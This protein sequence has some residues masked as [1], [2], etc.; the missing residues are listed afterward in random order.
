MQQ[1]M[2]VPHKSFLIPRNG[3]I[4][5]VHKEAHGLMYDRLFP[6]LNP[7]ICY[8]YLHIYSIH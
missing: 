3:R 6:L 7:I 4:S 1:N 8:L 2:I 5:L